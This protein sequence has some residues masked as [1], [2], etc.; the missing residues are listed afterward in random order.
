MF[1]SHAVLISMFPEVAVAL[2]GESSIRAQTIRAKFEVKSDLSFSL[3]IL[4]AAV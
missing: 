1:H 2:C 3:S 4:T